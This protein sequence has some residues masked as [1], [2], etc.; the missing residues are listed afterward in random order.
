MSPGVFGAGEWWLYFWFFAAA[1]AAWWLRFSPSDSMLVLVL[2]DFGRSPR[3]QYH[4]LSI[5]NTGR[6][7]DVIAYSG[8]KPVD[9]VACNAAVRIWA[10]R[11]PPALPKGLPRPMFLLYAPVKVLFQLVQL[12]TLLL[13]AVPRPS[14]ILVQNPPSIPT[15][16]VVWFAALMRGSRFVVDWHNYGYSILALGVG[17]AHW[18]VKL[19]E[20]L[21]RVFG[22]MATRHLCVTRAMQRDLRDNW[23]ITAEVLHDRPPPMFEPTPRAARHE[24]FS[25]LDGFRTPFGSTAVPAGGTLFTGPD[26]ALR[27]DRPALIVS[28]TSWTPDEDFAILLHALDL[29]EARCNSGGSRLPDVVCAITGKGPLRAHYEHEVA[30]RGYK[31]VRVVTLWLAIEDY[32]RL[33]G[34]A[35]IGVSL[36]TSSSGLDLPMKVA[37]ALRVV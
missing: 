28:S 4:T 7:V 36:H 31:H 3:M 33:L 5:A 8:A 12:A 23:G 2:G 22:A 19:A 26:G 21:E 10:V 29:I 16:Q 15:L 20:W 1:A 35:D 14:H 27:P 9:A 24:L 18:L 13:L 25:R 6:R 11:E 30:R 34:A 37:K 32:P 17:K